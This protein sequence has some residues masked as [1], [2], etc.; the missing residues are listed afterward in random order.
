MSRSRILIINAATS[1][2]REESA[3]SDVAEQNK[4][5]Q[6]SEEEKT[7]EKNNEGIWQ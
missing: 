6:T 3:V 5:G 1:K 2:S 7:K 4:E